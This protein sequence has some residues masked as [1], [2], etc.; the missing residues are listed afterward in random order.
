MVKNFAHRGMRSQ[1]P[2][3]TMLAFSKAVEFGCDGIELDILACA[4]GELVVAHDN[5]VSRVT[6]KSGLVTEMSLAELKKLNI[7]AGFGD[8]H[9]FNPYPTLE[10]YF[11]SFADADIIT[12]IEIKRGSAPAHEIE[13]RAVELVRR[14]GMQDRVVFSSFDHYSVMR[15]KK[16]APEIECGFLMSDSILYP[17]HYAAENGIEYVHPRYSILNDDVLS[18]IR[19]SG[20]RINV[21]TVNHPADMRRFIT[22]GINAIITDVPDILKTELENWKG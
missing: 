8:A 11:R 5:D 4:T 19:E 12:N 22:A 13:Q 2:E 17:G 15:V 16:L 18:E 7:T 9:G 20:T 10:E 1:Y 3:N 14:Y 21:Y 6:G